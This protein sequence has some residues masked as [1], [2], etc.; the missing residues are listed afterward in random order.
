MTTASASALAFSAQPIP[1]IDPRRYQIACLSGLLVWGIFGLSFDVV[2]AHMA[3]ML[4]AAQLTQA[5]CTRIFHAGAWDPKS[6][7]ISSLSLCLL[8]RTSSVAV[9]AAV[10]AVAVASKFVVRVRGKH[11]LNPTNGAIVLALLV[12]AP[13]WVSPGQWGNVTFFAFL[14]ACLGTM[15]VTRSSRV[16]VVVAFLV[17]WCVLVVGRSVWLGEPLTIP[18]HRL[19]SGALL[20]FAFFMISDP[21][22]TPDARIARILFAVVV[23][24][25]AW[26]VQ[27]RLFRT[28]GLLWSLFVCSLF[29]PLLD[30]V[31]AGPRFSWRVPKAPS[32]SMPSSS[33]L[34]ASLSASLPLEVR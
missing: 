10:A 23:A 24:G 14:M 31:F 2:P 11:V 13:V 22:T 8:L 1:A 28:N 25:G 6:A 4:V 18:A 20:L 32:S 29:V 16:D 7:L 15:T 17:S 27:F 19:Q 12:D 30:R 26:Y 5:A 33:T 9:A 3:V 34:P 21:K